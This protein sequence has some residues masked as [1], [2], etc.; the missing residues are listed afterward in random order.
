MFIIPV[1]LLFALLAVEIILGMA[2]IDTVSNYV[3]YPFDTSKWAREDYVRY[4]EKCRE[5]Y[6]IPFINS[7]LNMF[8]VAFASCY[9]FVSSPIATNRD[10]ASLVIISI[11]IVEAVTIFQFKINHGIWDTAP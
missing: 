1:K 3:P 8:I 4:A 7:R 2:I 9:C 5:A 6:F 11:A 10:F